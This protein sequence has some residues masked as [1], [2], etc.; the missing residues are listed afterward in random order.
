[1]SI[2]STAHVGSTFT[3]FEFEMFATLYIAIYILFMGFH[4]KLAL[5]MYRQLTPLS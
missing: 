5:D 3:E 4:G 1:M 2:Q